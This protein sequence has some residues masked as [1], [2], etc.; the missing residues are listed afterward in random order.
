MR[1]IVGSD[2]TVTLPG[3]GLV[4]Q[5]FDFLTH[6]E[7]PLV[8]LK[9]FRDVNQGDRACYQAIVEAPATLLSFRGGGALR[10][11]YLLQIK[12]LD[13]FPLVRDL[14]LKASKQEA[15]GAWYTEFDFVMGTGREVWRTTTAR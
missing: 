14:G 6:R 11:K 7:V 8:F 1:L 15:I 13:T 5:L 10:G 9:Q 4:L 12:S 3:L 2:G